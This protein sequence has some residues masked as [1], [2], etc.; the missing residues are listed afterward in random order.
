MRRIL[1]V[2]AC[3]AV[4]FGLMFVS[5]ASSEAAWVNVRTVRHPLVVSRNVAV[6]TT[7]V[8]TTTKVVPRVVT[9]SKVIHTFHPGRYVSYRVRR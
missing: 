2:A 9:T 6:K 1:K 3:A 8:V 7:T 4:A 5:T